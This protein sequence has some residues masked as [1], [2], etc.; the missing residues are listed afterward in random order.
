[1]QGGVTNADGRSSCD[2]GVY[3][4]SPP[5][6]R[7][8]RKQDVMTRPVPP[9]T[10]P[11]KVDGPRALRKKQ[12]QQQ[13]QVLAM[14]NVW[15]HHMEVNK[16]ENKRRKRPHACALTALSSVPSASDSQRW[17][18]VMREV[19]I[20]G[21]GMYV[22]EY[23]VATERDQ[24]EEGHRQQPQFDRLLRGTRYT[25]RGNFF[26]SSPHLWKSSRLSR[27]GEVRRRSGPCE[28]YD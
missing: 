28:H 20:M 10:L 21:I 13:Q 5:P 6:I 15:R 27:C 4:S 1:M 8:R 9:T 24:V 12:Q 22:G 16:N 11:P 2:S 7:H 14:K 19:F 23:V 3:R 18:G 25:C 17:C 26:L